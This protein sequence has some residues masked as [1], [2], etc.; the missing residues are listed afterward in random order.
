MFRIILISIITFMHTY[1]VWRSSSVPFLREHI[2]GKFFIIGGIIIWAI[3]FIGLSHGYGK[4]GTIAGILEFLGMSWMAVVFIAFVLLFITDIVTGFGFFLPRFS[5]YLRGITLVVVAMLTVIAFLQGMHAPVIKDYEVHLAELPDEMNGTV[6]AVLSDLHLGS[7]L[8][9]KWLDKRVNQVQALQPDMVVLLGDIFEGRLESHRKLLPI[10]RS[11]S[12]PLGTYAV[13]G[14]H[15]FY[16]GTE[17]NISL[18]NEA[19]IPVLRDSWVEVKPGLVL[20]GVDDASGF[21]RSGERNDSILKATTDL[22]PG[23]VILLSHQPVNAVKVAKTGVNLMLSGHTHG[24]QLWPFGYLV[25]RV[26]PLFAGRYEVSGMIVIVS[27][28]TGTWGPRMRLWHPGEIIRLKLLRK[29]KQD[30]LE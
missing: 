27:R 28:G 22:P 12:A 25:K 13:L 7:L 11:I 1:V 20:A 19:G 15:E 29:E 14:N 10:L 3:F 5:P 2:P 4:T 30:M 23:I 16:S 9:E 21:R 24:G 26:Y 8:G 17:R 18:F 6:I